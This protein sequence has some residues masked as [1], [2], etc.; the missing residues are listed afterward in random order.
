MFRGVGFGVP[1]FV[2]TFKDGF[3]DLQLKKKVYSNYELFF[4]LL[5]LMRVR[6]VKKA[7]EVVN[8]S[9]DSDIQWKPLNV[10]TG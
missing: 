2:I 5:V 1:Q 3:T 10:I 9:N 4:Y 6:D 8:Y 7:K